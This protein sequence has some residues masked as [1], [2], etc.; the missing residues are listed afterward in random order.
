MFVKEFIVSVNETIR[1]FHH[2]EN[3]EGTKITKTNS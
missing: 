2:K 1:N 3:K